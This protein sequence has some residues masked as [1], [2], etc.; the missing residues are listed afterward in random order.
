LKSS[1][2][3][4]AEEFT[5]VTLARILRP[6][7]LRGEVVAQILTDFPER[8]PKL[9]EVWLAGNRGA[10]RRVRVQ[11]C[12]LSPSRGGQAVFH[13]A[14]INCIEDAEG[15]RGLEVQVPIE[16]RARLDAG[17]YFV[18]DLLGCEV[19]EAGAASA[20]GSVRDVEF[21]GGAAALLAIDTNEGE[22]LIPLAA[23]F[24]V[25]IDVKA[26]RIDVAL[27]EGLR[28]LNRG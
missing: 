6:R 21:P 5:G 11:R 13:F 8:L 23:E 26:K 20:L 17:S 27:P 24:C 15:L 10:P 22:V 28:D 9:R 3:E 18:S 2:K 16:Q 7:G 4:P 19:W 1:N 14:D 25:H 12:W